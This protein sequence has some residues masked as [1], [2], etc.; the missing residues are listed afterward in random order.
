MNDFEIIENKKNINVAKN[1]IQ[2]E[3][4]SNMKSTLNKVKPIFLSP[5]KIEMDNRNCIVKKNFAI[6]LM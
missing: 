2:D 6:P 4:P 5:N 1:S 3:N